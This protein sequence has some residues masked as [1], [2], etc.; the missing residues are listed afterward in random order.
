VVTAAPA[1]RAAIAI[2][3]LR[4]ARRHGDVLVAWAT[5][6]PGAAARARHD[7]AAVITPSF[8]VLAIP[9]PGLTLVVHDLP[10][11]ALDNDIG[12]AI[13]AELVQPGL[14]A[15]AGA[16]ERCF[17][18]VVEST[19]PSPAQTWDRFYDNTLA[20]L[21]DP[22]REGDGPIA[23]FAAIYDH[24]RE[25]AAGDSVLDVGSCFAFFPLRIAGAFR[26]TA[27]DCHQPTLALARRTARRLGLPVTFAGAD[28][29]RP[30]PFADAG[31]DTVTALHV[32]EHLPEHAGP[33]VLAGLCRVARRRVIVAVPLEAAPDPSY[34]HR[35]AF[36]LPRL[37]SLGRAVTGWRGD[38]HELRGGWL[39]LEPDADRTAA[40]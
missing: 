19:G 37:A 38:A 34:G 6:N 8:T 39:V 17:A 15:G 7:V 40:S 2:D 23:T 9:A 18:G 32:L 33:A 31:V 26:V 21:G 25:L 24:A 3:R 27:S 13:A 28:I 4:W 1:P 10:P 22:A 20:A 35:Q 30:L 12:A 36:D 5:V 29:T 16:F 11:A 14:V